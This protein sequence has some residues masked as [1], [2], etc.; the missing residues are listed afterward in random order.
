M[1][2]IGELTKEWW[3]WVGTLPE[4]VQELCRKY[5]QN[6]LYRLK[7]TGH[8]VTI[9]SYSK[10]GTLTVNVTGQY[11]LIT[12][13]RQVFNV[14]PGDIEECD[15]PGDDEELGVM[16]TEEGEIDKF[17]NFIKSEIALDEI[18]NEIVIPRPKDLPQYCKVK[19]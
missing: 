1:A 17:I 7:S 10:N 8:R 18:S 14:S 11:N 12:F 6:K 4:N 13:E 9:Y 16:L 19:L 3:D 15:L 5:P 2:V